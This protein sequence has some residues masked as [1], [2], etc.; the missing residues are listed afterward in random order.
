[1]LQII[2]RTRE[3]YFLEKFSSMHNR[4]SP[5]LLSEIEVLLKQFLSS[6]IPGLPHR[7]SKGAQA[8]PPGWSSLLEALQETGRSDAALRADEGLKGHVSSA[9]S[10]GS[11]GTRIITELSL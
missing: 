3:Q 10:V 8:G 7:T 4:L 5:G 9:V 6:R 1:M 2:G 11:C